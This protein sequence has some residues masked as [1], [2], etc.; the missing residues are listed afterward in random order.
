VRE[1]DLITEWYASERVDQTGIPETAAMASSIP[2]GSRVLDVG[3]GNGIPIT[4][5]LLRAGHVVI[6][7]DSSSPMLERFRDNCPET[8]AIRS[9]VQ[10]CPFADGIFDAAVALG[11]YVPPHSGVSDQGNR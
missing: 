4:S 5:A 2:Y 1:Y 7:L 10:A 9:I 11:R 6:G 3:C 8:F